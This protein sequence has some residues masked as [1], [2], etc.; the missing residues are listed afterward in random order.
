MD[1]ATPN[2]YQPIIK[3]LIRGP[4]TRQRV[5]AERF[6][7]LGKPSFKLVTR[8]IK[9]QRPKDG[10]LITARVPVKVYEPLPGPVEVT[11]NCRPRHNGGIWPAVDQEPYLPG[12]AVKKAEP[13]KSRRPMT[14]S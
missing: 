3:S 10:H 6:P 5:G 4:R 14:G 2:P 1:K 9:A 12:Q 8:T 7:D 13:W 11:F